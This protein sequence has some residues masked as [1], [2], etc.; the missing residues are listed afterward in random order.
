M[1]DVVAAVIVECQRDRKRLATAP[2]G[3]G[4][5]EVRQLHE[6]VV[7]PQMG[8][9]AREPYPRDRWDKFAPGVSVPVSDF[10]VEQD[11]PGPAIRVP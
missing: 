11:E 2:G 10:V 6:P 3:D 8:K 4:G 9:L 5:W 7:A 1:C